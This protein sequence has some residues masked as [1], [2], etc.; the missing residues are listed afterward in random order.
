MGLMAQGR[1]NRAIAESLVI[2]ER[3]V[4]KHLTSIFT[5]LDLPPTAED[6]RRGAGRPRVPAQ[7]SLTRT[8]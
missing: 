3:A 4:E 7:P 2:S 5:R 8:R 1:S 6:H